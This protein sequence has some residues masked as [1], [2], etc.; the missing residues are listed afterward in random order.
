MSDPRWI[1]P[2]QEAQLLAQSEQRRQQFRRTR[3]QVN[4]SMAERATHLLSMYP[5]V[6]PGV[7][8]TALQANLSDEEFAELAEMDDGGQTAEEGIVSR[9]IGVVS[10]AVGTAADEVYEQ[11]I[12]PAIRGTFTALDMVS[13][14]VQRPFTAGLASI[15]QRDAGSF[16]EAYRDIG[17]SPGLVAARN[18]LDSDPE[19]EFDLGQGFFAGGQVREQSE[20]QNRLNIDGQQANLGRALTSATVGQFVDPGSKAY[21]VTAGV[22]QFAADV[23]GDPSAWATGGLTA[24]VRAG[25]F[26]GLAGNRTGTV[27]RTLAGRRLAGDEAADLLRDSAGMVSSPRR[28]TVLAERAETFFREKNLLN[29]LK[30]ADSYDI[31]QSFKK[32]PSNHIDRKLI[33]RLGRATEEDEVAEILLDATARGHL[34]RRGFY[35]GPTGFRRRIR[36]AKFAG[37]SPRGRVSADDLDTSADKLDSLLRQAEIGKEDTLNEFGEVVARGRRH[38]FNR[39][40]ELEDGDT[41][42]MFDVVTDALD[43]ISRSI[44]GGDADTSLR[45]VARIYE[46]Q[47]EAFRIYNID[48]VG[49]PIRTPFTKSKVVQNFDGTDVEVPIPTPAISSQL[50]DM[51]FE[52]PDAQTIRRAAEKSR[53]KRAVYKNTGW[54]LSEEALSFVTRSVFKPAAILRPA[55]VVRIGMEEQARLAASGY[56]SLFNHPFRFIMAN[57][58]GRKHG[59]DLMGGNLEERARAM[60]VITREATGMLEHATKSRSHM[61]GKLSKSNSE[62]YVTAWRHSLG[63]LAA[64]P[65]MRKMAELRGNVDEFAAWARGTTE[66]RETVNR[67]AKINDEARAITSDD[68]ALREWADTLTRIMDSQTGQNGELLDM[69]ASGRLAGLN[70]DDPLQNANLNRALRD[71]L[72]SAPAVMKVEKAA[73]EPGKLRAAYDQALNFTFDWITGKPTSYFARFP[74]WRQSI[75][76]N[77]EELMPNLADDTLRREAFES[78]A[79]NLNLTRKE[80]QRLAQAAQDASGKQGLL[81]NLDDLNEIAIERAG[82]TTKQLLFDITRRS[83]GQDAFDTIVPFLDAFKEVSMT[84]GRMV[85]ENPAFMIRGQAGYRSLE[86]GGLIYPNDHGD[87]VFSYPGGG[88]L[89]SFLQ[90]MNEGGGGLRA[91]PGAAAGALADTIT[92]NTPDEQ[93]NLEGRVEGVNLVVQGVGP[94]FGPVVQWATGAF[95]PDTPSYDRIREFLAPFGSEAQTSTDLLDPETY[96]QG[97]TPAWGNKLLQA[98]T[99]GKFDEVQWNSTVG[100]VMKVLAESGRYD[101]ANPEDQQ[102]LIEDA[103]RGGSWILFIRGLVQGVGP[104]GPSASWQLKTEMDPNEIPTDWDPEA[105]PDGVFHTI[106]TLANEYRSLAEHYDGDY[107]LATT[108]F[109]DIFGH[110][111]Y[112]L[113][114]AKSRSLVEAPVTE[115]GDKWM[116][117]NTEFATRHPV[118]AGYWAPGDEDADLEYGVYRRQFE[119]GKRQTLTAEQ[120]LQLANQTKARAIKNNAKAALE[121]RGVSGSR[122]DNL[123]RDVNAALED[124]FPGWQA[125]VLGVEQTVDQEERI[126]QLRKA[127]FD[128]A[129]ADEPLTAPLRAYLT[130][131]DLMQAEAKNR[132]YVTL[133]GQN[134]ADLR[135]RLDA[136]GRKLAESRPAFSGVWSRLLSREVEG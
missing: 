69:I 100:D 52:L 73:S 1:D 123:L 133:G 16:G 121:A 126:K 67:I 120:Q 47:V 79:N 86:E 58:A 132:G 53:V 17:N 81:D 39:M 131:R 3:N 95:V 9:G 19:T 8:Q 115:E 45:E 55:Y 122:K 110:E 129:V 104:T 108:K 111:P 128:P 5:N 20:A 134:V 84:W 105:D 112:Y 4:Q 63:Q 44:P 87:M 109:V 14:E 24:A 70:I 30:E 116:R 72:D 43:D 29:R 18:L 7:L 71:R 127:A 114:Q 35:S 13:K 49:D 6:S 119:S 78:A 48:S 46:R 33:D 135:E 51:A 124:K 57:V 68:G 21:D 2:D 76:R 28:N 130:F 89:S 101:P 125:P 90:R 77:V 98:W 94:G 61:W 10:E 106:G 22:T 25:R 64:A 136:F 26:A 59:A 117:R 99:S 31:Y 91:V 27:A 85:K 93:V 82:E 65:E 80:H 62:E 38:Y 42:G 54:D 113:S 118:V 41:A 103:E 15:T 107:Q 37:L 88:G 56:D 11:A 92:G 12:K 60:D 36:D 23:L 83:A 97:L 32:S 40:A 74:A 50:A 96:I 34:T 102:R 75:V 66:G